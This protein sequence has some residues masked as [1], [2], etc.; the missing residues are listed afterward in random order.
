MLAGHLSLMNWVGSR[1]TP[2]QQTKLLMNLVEAL[3]KQHH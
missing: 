1:S 3:P 2:Y